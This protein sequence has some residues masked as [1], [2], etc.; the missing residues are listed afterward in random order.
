MTT[1][2]LRVPEIH[3]GH[4]K[5]SIEGAVSALEGVESVTVDIEP[6]TVT[7]TYDENAVSL[8]RVKETIEEIGYEV[9]DDQ[10]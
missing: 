10:P 9:P 4:C 8:A 6:R 1:T 7:L 3:C 5:S 2:T